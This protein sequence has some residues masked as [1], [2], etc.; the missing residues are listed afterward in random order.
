[1]G[2]SFFVMKNNHPSGLYGIKFINFGL[3]LTHFS[4]FRKAR[5]EKL[6]AHADEGRDDSHIHLSPSS[7]FQP[8]QQSCDVTVSLAE[9]SLGWRAL[10]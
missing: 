4:N 10:T 2:L 9:A 7:N 1:M 8:K 6:P 5:I 3:T